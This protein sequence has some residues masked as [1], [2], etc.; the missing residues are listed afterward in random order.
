MGN[1][2]SYVQAVV[3]LAIDVDL[4]RRP[5]LLTGPSGFWGVRCDR[6]SKENSHA[7]ASGSSLIRLMHGH[8]SQLE[9]IAVGIEQDVMRSLYLLSLLL[10]ECAHIRD[11]L[12][13]SGAMIFSGSACSIDGAEAARP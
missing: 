11:A 3:V 8:V 10:S 4:P 1:Q 9:D 7:C 12:I 13:K 5:V 2:K 6:R